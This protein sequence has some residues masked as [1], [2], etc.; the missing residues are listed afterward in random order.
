MKN[1]ILV[2]LYKRPTFPPQRKQVEKDKQ[3]LPPNTK[4]KKYFFFSLKP[5]QLNI[6]AKRMVHLRRKHL[7]TKRIIN[8]GK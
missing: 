6:I 7:L 8:L 3:G 1:Y 4:I 2:Y 5:V